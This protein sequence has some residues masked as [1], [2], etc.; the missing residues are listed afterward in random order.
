MRRFYKPGVWA[1][2]MC[3]VLISSYPRG[4]QQSSR[5]ASEGVDGQRA[6]APT[7]SAS[8]RHKAQSLGLEDRYTQMLTRIKA[9]R[10][11]R[12]MNELVKLGDEIELNWGNLD[13]RHYASLMLE[14]SNAFSS[15]NL[16]DDN[17][18]LLEQK[19]AALVLKKQ[20]EIPPDLEAQLVLHLQEDIEYAKGQLSTEEWAER[21]RTKAELWL[22]T[23][24]HLNSAIDPNF[25]FKDLPLLNVPLPPGVAGAAGMA[26]ESIKDPTL[27]AQYQ[28]AIEANEKKAADFR[29]QFALRRTREIFT[30]RMEAY[31]VRA[32]SRP[33]DKASEVEAILKKYPVDENMRARVLNGVKVRNQ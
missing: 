20:L 24:Q 18:Y 13:T 31:L 9:A 17:Q 33:P 32:Y 23:W 5:V 12:K 10:E 19:Y 21:R 15:T 8:A 11:L 1:V 26:P 28:S 27:R 16:N 22:R 4:T 7:A 25:N 14:I 6:I 29:T 2:F 30:Q 3:T